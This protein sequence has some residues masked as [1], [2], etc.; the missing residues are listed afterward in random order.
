[1]VQHAKYVRRRPILLQ[2]SST[3]GDVDFAKVGRSCQHLHKSA[4]SCT[5]RADLRV[6]SS[7]TLRTCELEMGLLDSALLHSPKPFLWAKV[8]L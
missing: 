5:A 6:A 1:M 8:I 7:E 3:A 4:A 2:G